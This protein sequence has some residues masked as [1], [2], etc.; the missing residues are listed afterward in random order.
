MTRRTDRVN[1]LLREEL[2]NLLLRGL[3]DPRVSHGLVTITEVRTSPDLR[4]ATVYVSHLG[5]EGERAGVLDG[6]TH[7]AHYLHNELVKRLDLRNVP[8][9]LFRFDPSIERGDRLAQLIHKVS[10]ERGETP[11]ADPE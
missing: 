3:K 9:L 8:E 5:D 6:L 2:S 7:A 11:G 10:T 1:E 4:H